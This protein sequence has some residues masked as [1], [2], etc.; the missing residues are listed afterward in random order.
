M[1]IRRRRVVVHEVIHQLFDPHGIGGRQ[2]SMLEK[3][4]ARLG[5]GSGVHVDGKRRQRVR[6]GR[7]KRILDDQVVLVASLSRALSL[8]RCSR[9]HFAGRRHV[10]GIPAAPTWRH[11]PHSRI[12][13]SLFAQP[14][15]TSPV[16]T[17]RCKQGRR[18]I[19][20]FVPV[21]VGVGKGSIAGERLPC[22]VAG[23]RQT[24]Q[25]DANGSTKYDATW[26]RKIPWR[27]K[28]PVLLCADD[29]RADFHIRAF[30]SIVDAEPA[31]RAR[32]GT[33]GA[34]CMRAD[35]PSTSSV[36]CD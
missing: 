14:A 26:P 34:E 19:M 20:T 12:V 17:T 5:V 32:C 27:E 25:P 16:R 31:R 15:R 6:L 11:Y 28:M 21:S 10:P 18:W 35:S 29:R 7:E 24:H 22:A 2:L 3:I 13:L 30:C 9:W 33:M 8:L 23:Q 4:H 36:D 1:F